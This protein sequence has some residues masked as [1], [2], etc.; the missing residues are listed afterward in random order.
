MVTEELPEPA[1]PQDEAFQA[2]QALA[3]LPAAQALQPLREALVRAE[4]AALPWHRAFAQVTLA[5]AL[6]FRDADEALALGRAGLGQMQALGSRRGQALAHKAIGLAHRE[7]GEMADC[8]AALEQ[9]LELERALGDIPG[10]A[11]TLAHLSAPLERVGR[12]DAAL[13]CLEEA[14]ALLP[15]EEPSLRLVLRNNMAAALASRARSERDEGAAAS[16]WQASAR[17]AEAMA[18][19]LMSVPQAERQA[20]LQHPQYPLGCLA[21]ALLV[22]DRGAEAMPILQQLQQVYSAAG[23][24]YALLYVQLE[25]ARGFLQAG[26]PAQAL[27]IIKAAIE[28]AQARHF[29]HFLESL[30]ELLAQAHEAL[31][32]HREALQAFRNFHRLKLAVAVERAEERARTLA[33]RLETA[34]AQRESRRDALTGLLNRRGFDELLAAQLQRASHAQPVTLLLIDLDHFKAVNDQHGHGRG[35]Q[36]LVLLA[37]L[38]R[39]GARADD[40]AARLGGDELA[41][42]GQVDAGNARHVA[43]RLRENL[44]REC[45]TRWPDQQPL[46]VSIG[47]AETREPCAAQAL[48]QRADAALYAAKAAGRDT[49]RGG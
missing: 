14:L 17:Q 44:R 9:A 41:W 43:E 26:E 24:N 11:R 32:E 27:Q 12:R 40:H 19:E 4:M 35:D 47:L 6:F 38:L 46:T 33:V 5:Q 23:D 37:Q 49:V 20:S 34:R 36:A 7:R 3:R 13:Q 10:Q 31:G 30:W 1:P 45:A 42:F 29:E 22:L 2:L 15:E 28:L 8:L 25:Q 48:V 21:K 39:H 18:R 16:V